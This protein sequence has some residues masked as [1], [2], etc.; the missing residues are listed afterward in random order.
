MYSILGLS[1]QND[2]DSTGEEHRIPGTWRFP[3][4]D[5]PL[6]G[7]AVCLPPAQTLTKRLERADWARVPAALS[8]GFPATALTHTWSR[9]TTAPG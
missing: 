2:Q 3:E 8:T 6:P 5:S 7:K 9:N 1:P 4:G